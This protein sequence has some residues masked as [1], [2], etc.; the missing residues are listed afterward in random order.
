PVVTPEEGCLDAPNGQYPSTTYTP[1]CTGAPENITTLAWTGEYSMVSVTAGTEYVFSSSVPTD[2][3][4]I[5]D[6]NG[7]TVYAAGTTPVTWTAT[8][9]E[10]IRF[11]LH[12]D[13]DCNYASTGLRSRIVQCGDILPPPDND[14]CEDAIE[15]ACGDSVQGS[16]VFATNSGG[17]AAAD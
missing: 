12:L 14:D 13:S 9:D 17:N 2:F 6:A 11:Y 15:I 16:T 8:A 1:N 4:T 3:I 10:A 7:T 5:S